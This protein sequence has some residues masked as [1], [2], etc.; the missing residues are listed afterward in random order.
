MYCEAA[1]E[2]ESALWR[3]GRSLHLYVRVHKANVFLTSSV[4]VN[5][6]GVWL[7]LSLIRNR[8]IPGILQ[9]PSGSRG[10]DPCMQRPQSAA[11]YTWYTG[12]TFLSSNSSTVVETRT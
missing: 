12:T 8:A 9:Q 2:H 4:Y 6:A 10:S 11:L 3:I 5:K 1:F 7:S